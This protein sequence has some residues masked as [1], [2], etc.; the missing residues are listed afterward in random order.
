MFNLD[1]IV[2]RWGSLNSGIFKLIYQ[3]FVMNFEVE[4]R[5][6]V[7]NGPANR[8]TVLSYRETNDLNLNEIC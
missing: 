8:R 6:E 2:Q 3:I 1:N 5:V 7:M 4:V